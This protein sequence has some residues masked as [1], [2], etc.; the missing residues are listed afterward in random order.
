MRSS[1]K[2]LS[3]SCLC[4]GVDGDL[5][6][7]LRAFQRRWLFLRSCSLGRRCAGS[8]DRHILL[9]GDQGVFQCGCGCLQRL[10]WVAVS[11]FCAE[12]PRDRR[13]SASLRASCFALT[14]L[15]A[16]YNSAER[17][18][19]SRACV[20]CKLPEAEQSR[21]CPGWMDCLHLQR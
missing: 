7:G 11:A 15:R 21:G 5:S 14:P 19:S 8:A 9:P 17:S 2:Y 4:A 13:L 16:V 1:L 10:G 12:P 18:V 3:F 20:S 6:G